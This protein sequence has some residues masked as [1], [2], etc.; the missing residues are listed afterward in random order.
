MS[1]NSENLRNFFL[2]LGFQIYKE[3]KFKSFGN[4][5]IEACSPQLCARAESDRLIESIEFRHVNEADNWFDMNV[6]IAA[7]GDEQKLVI[8]I[9]LHAE[10]QF[11]RRHFKDIVTLFADERYPDTKAMFEEL[12]LRRAKI[13][14]PRWYT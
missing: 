2:D 14:F 3:E 6:I 11:I 7:L 13:L 9:G 10:M 4:Y 8:G 1:N 12:Q 5:I